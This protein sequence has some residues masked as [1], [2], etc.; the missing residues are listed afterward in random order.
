MSILE[1]LAWSGAI[2]LVGG[3][4]VG[5]FLAAHG[6]YQQNK[7]EEAVRQ[8]LEKEQAKHE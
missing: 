2:L 1:F 4:F 6:I 5:F 7:T 3:F 8:W